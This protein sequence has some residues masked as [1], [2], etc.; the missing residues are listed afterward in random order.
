MRNTIIELGEKLKKASLE[1]EIKEIDY[2]SVTY[3]NIKI[4]PYVDSWDEEGKY[5]LRLSKYYYEDNNKY[6]RGIRFPLSK[7]E[8]DYLFGIISIVKN[9]FK[10]IIA[11]ELGLDLTEVDY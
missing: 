11:D 10:K 8:C 1:D 9:T 3:N 7:E 2:C 6:Y 4:S 5:W